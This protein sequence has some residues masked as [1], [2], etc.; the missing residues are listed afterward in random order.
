VLSWGRGGLAACCGHDFAECDCVRRRISGATDLDVPPPVYRFSAPV[1]FPLT[2]LA[3]AA[4]LLATVEEHAARERVSPSAAFATLAGGASAMVGHSQG[5]VIAA[6]AAS[7]KDDAEFI[8][9]S[10]DAVA[11]LF[12]VGL[13][14]QLAAERLTGSDPHTRSLRPAAVRLQRLRQLE[15]GA[16][17]MLSVP[18]GE[19][20]TPMLAVRGLEAV[21]LER[22]I[23]RV[24]RAMAAQR[25]AE[26]GGTDRPDTRR[27]SLALSLV[28]A[29]RLC[30]V[31]GAA[32]ALG[33]LR[34]AV[35]KASAARGEDQA[36]V[37]HS[38]RKPTVS[39]TFL[40][41]SAP[42]HNPDL[43]PV[44]DAVMSDC[45]AF[46]PAP[47]A[48]S[49]AGLSCPVMDTATGAP[50]EQPEGAASG[51]LAHRLVE[52]MCALPMRWPEAL[53]GAVRCIRGGGSPA[54]DILVLDVGPGGAGAT[55]VLTAMELSG[56]GAVVAST[57]HVAAADLEEGDGP[58][59]AASSQAAC[60]IVPLGTVPAAPGYPGIARVLAAIP[61]AR[62][63][64]W[65]CRFAPRVL[66]RA[67]DGERFLHTRLTALLGRPPIIVAGMTPTTS[68]HGHRLVAAC[69][70]AGFTAELAGGGLPRKHVFRDRVSRL[71]ALLRPGAA[72]GVNLLFLNQRQWAFQFPLV[73]ELRRQGVPIDGLTVAAG[74]PSV[75]K[76]TEIITAVQGA[77]MRYVALKPGSVD[78]IR[79]VI[80]IAKANPDFP[81]VVQ[82]TGGRAGGHHSFE[83]M[84]APMLATY[85]DLRS[86]DNIV[87]VA[88]SGI[89][90]SSGALPYITGEWSARPPY[91][92]AA[93]PFDGVLVASRMMVAREAATA[94]EVK[95]MLVDTPGVSL[96]RQAEWEASYDADAGGVI[97]V[98]SELGEPIHK[99][100]NR[101]MR[102]W[103]QLDSEFFSMP[104]A[105]RGAAVAKRRAWII[106]RLNA[107]FQKEYFGRK[108]SGEVCG[109]EEMTYAEV[110][111]RFVE[112]TFVTR[113]REHEDPAFHHE[114]FRAATEGMRG[115]WLDVTF[116]S[117]LLAVMTRCLERLGAP[118]AAARAVAEGLVSASGAGTGGACDVDSHPE[119]VV[120]AFCSTVPGTSEQLLHGEDVAFFLQLC[121]SGGKPVPFV[122]VVDGELEFWFKKDSLWYSEDL[123]AVRDR[124]AGRV[125]VLQGPVAV[126]HATIANEPAAAIL[127]GIHEGL[128]EHLAKAA[129]AA[130]GAGVVQTLAYHEHAASGTAFWP[131]VKDDE[132]RE[133]LPWAAALVSTPFTVRGTSWVPSALPRLLAQRPGMRRVAS[134]DG[135]ELRLVDSS[136]GRTLLR[137]FPLGS[138]EEAAGSVRHVRVV[139]E[140]QPPATAERPTPGLSPL[141]LDFVYHPETAWAPVHEP[142]GADGGLMAEVRAFYARLW[143][144]EAPAELSATESASPEIVDGSN[145]WP[146]RVQTE[147]EHRV[148]RADIEAYCASANLPVLMTTRP[149]GS[150]A[151]GAAKEGASAAS[152]ASAEAS[153][154]ADAAADLPSPRAQAAA[155]AKDSVAA[156]PLGLSIVAAW[157]ALIA[158]LLAPSIDGNLLELVHLSHGHEVIEPLATLRSPVTEGEMVR[159]TLCIT[160]VRND[161]PGKVV[162]CEGVSS[163]RC[164]TGEWQ[165]WLRIRSRFLFRGTFSDHSGT[166]VAMERCFDLRVKDEAM[167]RVLESKAWLASDV[168]VP[169]VGATLRAQFRVVEEF[170]ASGKG[171]AAVR[172]SGS[173]ARVSGAEPAE[174]SSLGGARPFEALAEATA[175]ASLAIEHETV[176]TDGVAAFDAVTAFFERHGQAAAPIVPLH[177][178]VRPHLLS[179][180]DVSRAPAN[181]LAYSSASR[182]L[183]P[184][185]RNALVASLAG[186]PGT[187]THGMWTSANAQRVLEA[188]LGGPS[189]AALVRSFEASFEGM[190]LPDDELVTQVT[191]VGMRSGRRVLSI[192]TVKTLT[193]DVVLRASAEVDQPPTAF[194]FTGQ[195]S[196]SVGMGMDLYASSPDARK[197]WDVA[198]AQLLTTYGF[199]LLSIVRENPKSLTVHF[200]GR[201]G[202]AIRRNFQ[203]LSFED[204]H[205][206]A[207]A[208]LPEINDDTDQHTFQHPE[209]LLFATQFTQPALV[210]T[211]KAAFE[212]MR[213]SQVL[214]RGFLLAGH[215][216][217]EYA[218]LSAAVP[219]LR[220]EDLVELVFLR[221]LV[222][223][224]SVPRDSLGRS[225]FAMVACNPQRVASGFTESHLQRL[226][227]GIAKASGL[228]LQIVNYNVEDWQYV[229]TGH[230]TALRALALA[231][232]AIHADPGA[233]MASPEGVVIAA[234]KQARVEEAR[235][236]ARGD[237]APL[238]RGRATIPLPGIDVPFHSRFLVTGVPAFRTCLARAITQEGTARVL[239]SVI[240]RYVPNLVAM[241]FELSP[242][243]VAVVYAVTNSPLL[244]EAAAAVE[245]GNLEAWNRAVGDRVT[246]ARSLLLELMAF[247]FASPVQW[248]NTQRHFFTLPPDNRSTVATLAE[249]AAASA[250]AAVVRDAGTGAAVSARA[251]AAAADA[252]ASVSSSA[253]EV[254]REVA[255]LVPETMAAALPGGA[256]EPG[257]ATVVEVGPAATLS[258]MALR[259]LGFGR[260]GE[261]RARRVLFHGRD[262]DRDALFFS[263]ED[264]GPGAKEYAE[265]RRSQRAE[266]EAAVA[267]ASGS[268]AADRVPAAQPASAAASSAASPAPAPAAPSAAAPSPPP[269]AAPAAA[270]VPDGPLTPLLAVRTIAAVRA[271][272]SIADVPASKSLKDICAGKSALQNEIMGELEKEFAGAGSALEGAEEL[273]LQD[274]AA[275]LAGALPGYGA[276]GPGAALTPLVNKMGSAKLP[277]GFGLSSARSYLRSS[278]GLGQGRT[279][280]VLVRALADV[281]AQRLADPAAAEAWLDTSAQGYG[282]DEGVSLAKGAAGAAPGAAGGGGGGDL[283]ALLGAAGPG[284]QQAL[285][286]LLQGAAGGRPTGAMAQLAE[287]NAEAWT[288]FLR[289]GAADA[290]AVGPT[291][292]E[293]TQRAEAEERLASIEA[294]HGSA[295]EEG[296]RSVFHPQQVRSFTSYWN[297]ASLDLLEALFR[298]CEP[299]EDVSEG[300][301]RVLAESLGNRSTSQLVRIADAAAAGGSAAA[302]SVA[303]ALRDRHLRPAVFRPAL[304][305][306]CPAARVDSKGRTHVEEV[307]REGESSASDYVSSIGRPGTDGT[308]ILNVRRLCPGDASALVVDPAATADLLEVMRRAATDG[309]TFQDKTALI[310]GCGRGSIGA[311][312]VAALLQG[313]ARVVATTSRLNRKSA[314]AFQALFERHGARGSSLTLVPFNQASRVDVD[315][316]VGHVYDK[317]G[318]DLDYVVPFAAIGEAGRTLSSLD[319]RTELAHRIMLTNTLRLLGAVVEAKRSRGIDTRPA[320]AVLPLS[321][322][323]GVFG[324][325]G[326]YAESKLGLESLMRKWSAEG[327]ADY[328]SVAGA[329]IGWTRGTGLMSDN[330]VVAAGIEE[331]GCRTFSQ[332][333]MAFNL[334]SVMSQTMARVAA[335]GPVWA[336]LRGG[337]QRVPDLKG[338]VD[339]IRTS[340]RTEAA[341]AKAVATDA[342]LDKPPVA[343]KHLPAPAVERR[344]NWTGVSF[345][346]LPSAEDAALGPLPQGMSDLDRTVVVVGFGELGPWGSSRTRW[347]MERNGSLS[348]EGV[349][350][351]AW[352]TGRIRFHDGPLDPQAAAKAS[353]KVTE[354]ERR[355][356][357]GWVD[358]SSGTPVRDWDVQ[359]H[360]EAAVLGGCGVRVIE[361]EMV[362]GYDPG[363]KKLLRQV[364]VGRDLPWIEISSPEEADDYRAEAG[365]ER[366]QVRQRAEDGAW[367]MRLLAGASISVARALRFDRWV[368]GQLPTG[369]DA[370]RCGVPADLAG[371]ID[372]VTLFAL[373]S[374]AEAL[375]A[376]GLTDPYE[377]YSYCHLSEVGSTVGGGMG[378]MKSL[379]QIFRERFTENE[380]PSDALQ[381]TFINTTAAWI[382]MLLLSS[383]GPIKT[384]VGAC[385][386]AAES[387]DVAVDT[388][389]SGRAR[390]MICGGTDDFGEEG[391]YEFASMGATSS[392]AKE[393]AM[394]REPSEMSRP[395]AAS[396]GGFMES[397]GAGIQVLMQAR[398]AIALGAPIYGVVALT[399]TATDKE[400]R[401]VPAP[402]QGILTTARE[403]ALPGAAAAATRKASASRPVAAGAQLDS[404]AASR[405][406]GD[407]AAEADVSD[408]RS[409]ASTLREP[410]H[411]D[412]HNSSMAEAAEAEMRERVAA[413]ATPVEAA[414]VWDELRDHRLARHHPMLPV[415]VR[416][417]RLVEELQSAGARLQQRAAALD[418]EEADLDALVADHRADPEVV[419]GFTARR[420]ALRE[421]AAGAVSAAF[422]RW[423]TDV[424]SASCHVSPLRAGLAR[425]GLLPDDIAVASFHGTGTK[426]NDVNESEVTNAQMEALGR[427]PG[428]PVFVIA[429]KGLTGHP[430]GA[431]AA[432]MLN[433]LLQC[434]ADGV[435]PGN[436]NLDDVEPKLRA[437]THLVYPNRTVSLAPR[438]RGMP[439]VPAAIMKSFGFGQAGAELLVVHPDILLGTLPVHELEA[440][441]AR[442][443]RREASAYRYHQDVLLGRRELLAVKSSPPFAEEHEQAVYLDS[444]ARAAQDPVTREWQVVPSRG[445]RGGAAAAAPLGSPEGRSWVGPANP[446]AALVWLGAT[447]SAA[448]S[449]AAVAPVSARSPP[450]PGRASPPASP[451]TSD[452]GAAGT[453]TEEE[454][455]RSVLGAM[456]AGAAAMASAG[457]ART[458]YFGVDVEPVATLAA[459]PESMLERNFTAAERALCAKRPDPTASLAGRWAAKEA[460]FKALSACPGGPASKG[461][462]AALIDVEVLGVE[463]SAPSVVLHG[464]MEAAAAAAGVVRVHVTISHA[465]GIA[466]AQA[467]AIL[468]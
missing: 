434:M 354:T 52:L 327:W 318:L 250:V 150:G 144:C 262:E 44:C 124:D 339:G 17:Q 365:H 111:R 206:H 23:Y 19:D 287:D 343:A 145:R 276:E 98:K 366:V 319:D 429:Q 192:A 210:V 290:R 70:N 448:A 101:G 209:G 427:T 351:L 460:V 132:G 333:E 172:A 292:D 415:A 425:W 377:L 8:A 453:G 26:V 241:P 328:L 288:T 266:E 278:W 136:T 414:S 1:S 350:E 105:D 252:I 4:R 64:N 207:I 277:G 406:E 268:R 441:A 38:R 244:A 128:V 274:V 31:T 33:K 317:L 309:V 394:A 216:L 90:D 322:N 466:V 9:K 194:V 329:S 174:V 183:N 454:A 439:A 32:E 224:N 213:A 265:A 275:K 336:D 190:V 407:G 10:L 106:E 459:A 294:E 137:A 60:A 298:P 253:D 259:T 161:R 200:G 15:S 438:R 75:D 154:P 324:G 219:L 310:T 346:A 46:H 280:A 177:E 423:C 304:R 214:P 357:A 121:R 204:D 149:G 42:F 374:A 63:A 295:Y 384:V 182:D 362:E 109:I 419:A 332:A 110:L 464:T 40:P 270:Q 28:N 114:D 387:V 371:R 396:R 313:G 18:G 375:V 218:A 271:G 180:P 108:A 119:E 405:D 191:H 167:R 16:S 373:V 56:C 465:G 102:L 316:L 58:R 86:C 187:I 283:A 223:Q 184:I 272:A 233:A 378:G 88:G 69:A 208:L 123:A 84:H 416:R 116:R 418:S 92:R 202:A 447:P 215:S 446:V 127:G 385:A 140:D 220:T 382:N 263:A 78:A 160:E 153:A 445:S 157:R 409:V 186:L 420:V 29:S 426:A 242:R 135:L 376:S 321:P 286:G 163:R 129:G 334:V 360:Y 195:G 165:P 308:P 356:Y 67:S 189:E 306:T 34:A 120:D 255:R 198:D 391:S 77:G 59:P 303:A 367:E 361:P 449:S 211:E 358:A 282:K 302:A 297:W 352:L 443:G 65:G 269:A 388:I 462:A 355:S 126:R 424:C 341:V 345:P 402:G 85:A 51:W 113:D 411:P 82:W 370:K 260:Y 196:A 433:G 340:L 331:L 99:V 344:S 158:P 73:L 247:Q 337:M 72:F 246:L 54:A 296:I 417:E 342:A 273:P 397:Q 25:E 229:C 27:E 444:T 312:I 112:L 5:V 199:S 166:F 248:I 430:K 335:D 293:L 117:R 422:R 389:Q 2:G 20:A 237:Q 6:V 463:H 226:V 193:G 143:D 159:S 39:T 393:S 188:S 230:R 11:L 68:F 148:S 431:A 413:A 264:A 243:F 401:S 12:F 256:G 249:L 231:C 197:V 291:R 62:R 227:E 456:Q 314:A 236:L 320:L 353:W 234:V 251:R 146:L 452:E 435:V 390:V 141:T 21:D 30:V 386:T 93:M 173:L 181:N 451:V 467:A 240:H 104:P 79:R 222:M 115:R 383:A 24:K 156:A 428:R 66:T 300:V 458:A 368:A 403:C 440:Y 169:E 48:W 175:P 71:H 399:S 61:P 36:R 107:D 91:N 76:A 164:A 45:A 421:E 412:E 436:R 245:E 455:A 235:A 170:A 307:P 395:M 176:A 217:G 49:V 41:V 122:P 228:L 410:T 81:V 330:D 301:G 349:I 289:G 267:A 55:P 47:L 372:R 461:A 398:L 258:R 279:E 134:A 96:D 432:W 392:A 284:A 239:P 131:Q 138:A 323:H 285:A 201:R 205:G 468:A 50:I 53:R 221:G 168:P 185:H 162:T 437:F 225:D 311:E 13:R 43:L 363:R 254:T 281:P 325:D 118:D 379:R 347:E 348:V 89:G 74:V 359:S 408:S 442:R 380:M 35:T 125:C 87:L 457:S 238:G 232:D 152:A 37:P 450:R 257:V 381:E 7:S 203:A 305:P 404:S 179:E 142:G 97:T 100:A 178:G 151:E 147:C 364:A 14:A 22:H 57:G 400:G 95:Q 261:P 299:D 212:H 139:L 171:A 133:L 80:A 130:A 94:P 315:R 83:D 103:R 3:S 338:T 369:W 155:A 326:L